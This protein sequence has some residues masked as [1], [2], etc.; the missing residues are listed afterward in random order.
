MG[1]GWLPEEG[2]GL[3]CSD[4]GFCP[5]ALATEKRRRKEPETPRAVGIR[6]REEPGKTLKRREEQAL[7]STGER[8]TVEESHPCS[9]PSHP[10]LGGAPKFPGKE[11]LLRWGSGSSLGERTPCLTRALILKGSGNGPSCGGGS[12]WLPGAQAVGQEDREPAGL[13]ILQ[14]RRRWRW[15]TGWSWAH[16]SGLAR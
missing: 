2:R 3:L 5:V 7:V 15:L 14:E 11:V 16:P 6:G 13:C 8:Y 4:C 1:A 10:S 9:C 12:F